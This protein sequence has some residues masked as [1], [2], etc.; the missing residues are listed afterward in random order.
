MNVV[1]RS[2]RMTREAFLDWAGRQDIRHEFDGFQPVAMVG[3]SQRHNRIAL[4]AYSA[5]RAGLR[6]T[7]CEAFAMDAGIAT[8]GDAV[9]YSDALVTCGPGP[10]DNR[11]IP[12]VVAVFEVLSPSSSLTDRHTKL[13]EYAAVATIRHYVLLEQETVAAT[14]FDRPDG[15]SPWTATPLAAGAMLRLASLD[16]AIPIGEFYEGVRWSGPD[17]PA[18]AAEGQD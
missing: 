15:E 4:N 7:P 8:F 5:L 16:L 9:R 18:V 14:L 1:L 3:G 2:P 6:G 13:G 11:L 10:G 12:G 17:A